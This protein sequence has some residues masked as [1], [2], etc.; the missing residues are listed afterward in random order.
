[1]LPKVVLMLLQEHV[2]G[3]KRGWSLTRVVFGLE[4]LLGFAIISLLTENRSP[5]EAKSRNS[6]AL[7]L[8]NT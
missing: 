2:M 1:M 4:I 7:A 5:I 8:Y 3:I 6:G